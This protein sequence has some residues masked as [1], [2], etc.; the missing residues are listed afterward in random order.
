M[1]IS[2]TIRPYVLFLED[3][4]KITGSTLDKYETIAKGF[5]KQMGDKDLD[6]VDEVDF[7]TYLSG[8]NRA[9]RA[10][11]YVALHYAA[12]CRFILYLNKEHKYRN[13]TPSDFI[14]RRP[15]IPE[16]LPKAL[17]PWQIDMI[18][19]QCENVEDEFL[20]TM[21]FHTGLRIAELLSLTKANFDFSEKKNGAGEVV[22][23]R[24]VTVIGKGNKQRDIPLDKTVCAVIDRLFGFR[25]MKYPKGWA[26]IM[27]T[28]YWPVYKRI[29]SSQRRQAWRKKYHRIRSGIASLRP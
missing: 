3:D 28:G 27:D 20:I 18:M 19:E 10:A 24:W 14:G 11:S 26:K 21:L 8:M 13:C 6:A 23:T 15:K 29:G 12:L 16:R 7:M 2:E 22:R 25:D 4:K 17:E 9:G 1:K 5:I